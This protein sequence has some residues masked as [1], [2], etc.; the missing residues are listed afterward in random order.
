MLDNSIAGGIPARTS[1]RRS[2]E[3]EAMEEGSIPG[4]LVEKYAKAVGV[5]SYFFQ[6]KSKGL[7]PEAEFIYDMC[8]PKSEGLRLR[9]SD[10]EVESFEVNLRSATYFV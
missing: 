4:V 9:P 7:Q 5:I 1:P 2:I 6:N 8:V 10:N 3:K